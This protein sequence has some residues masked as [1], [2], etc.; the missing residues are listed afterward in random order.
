MR[1][2]KAVGGFTLIEVMVALLVV[3]FALSTLMIQM[4]RQVDAAVHLREKAVAH[5]VALNQLE[6]QRLANLDNTLL[7]TNRSGSDE[8]AGQEWFWSIRPVVSKTTMGT[9]VQLHIEVRAN[10]KDIDPLVAIVGLTDP[11]H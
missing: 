4:M 5:W 3:V 7:E 6:Y 10:E 11:Y 1:R 8:M 2:R 9:Y